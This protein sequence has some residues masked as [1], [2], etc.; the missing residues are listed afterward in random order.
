MVCLL[1]KSII[2]YG[3]PYGLGQVF[4]G[5]QMFLVAAVAFCKAVWPGFFF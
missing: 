3:F 2:K 5:I 4:Q 1:V